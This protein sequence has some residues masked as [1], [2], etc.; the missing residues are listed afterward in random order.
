MYN[1][2]HFTDFKQLQIGALGIRAFFNISQLKKAERRSQKFALKKMLSEI[3]KL[4]KYVFL[5]PLLRYF[6]R[7]TLRICSFACSF[8]FSGEIKISTPILFL[9]DAKNP[10]KVSTDLY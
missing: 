5:T 10:K 7:I 4:F 3:E 9:T 2:L 1:K 6:V 8:Y